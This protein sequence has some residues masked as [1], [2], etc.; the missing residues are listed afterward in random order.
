[1][2]DTKNRLAPYVAIAALSTFLD[3]IRNISLPIEIKSISLEKV[4]IS[5]SNSLALLSALKFL[6]LVDKRGAPT[7]SLRSLQ[8]SGEEFKINLEKIVRSAYTDLFSLLDPAKDDREHLRNYFARTYSPATAEKATA[9]F[10]DLCDE[11]GIPTKAGNLG[12]SKVAESKTLRVGLGRNK[13]PKTQHIKDGNPR[14]EVRIDSK[15]FASMQPEQIRAFFEGL[16][17]VT[18]QEEKAEEPN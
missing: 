8:T 13:T 16:N 4:G 18:K 2:K 6:G 5:K 7:E 1:M 9:L 11:A 3:R 17:R 14:F 10:L 15:D 12:K